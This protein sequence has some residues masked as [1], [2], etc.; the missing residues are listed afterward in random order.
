MTTAEPSADP[1]AEPLTL[2]CVPHAGGSAR[3][4]LRWR[5]EMPAA[6]R[7]APLEIAGRGRRTREPRHASLQEAAR[8]LADGLE[9]SGRYAIL[10]HS[11]GGLIAHE[12]ARLL[13][14]R[15]TAPEFLVVAATRPCHLL[16][17][18]AYAPLLE[19]PDDLLLETLAEHATIPAE[20][21]HSPMRALFV[22]VIRGDLELIAGYR[23][24]LTAEP[25]PVELSAWYGTEDATTPP[26]VM[27]DWQR[28]T[29][30][31]CRVDAFAGGHFFLHDHLE[32]VAARL[33]ELALAGSTP[34][35]G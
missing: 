30:L 4:F 22:P 35:T 25:L 12:L 17:P 27:A 5:R 18:D 3:S 32:P 1:G 26:E 20:L 33:V 21:V 7:V 34:R 9:P 29:R 31:P 24:D 23:P 6:V 13:T 15:G 14:D 16:S 10:G 2:Y 28:H 11:M 19:L 8:D